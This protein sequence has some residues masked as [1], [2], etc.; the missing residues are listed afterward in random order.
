MRVL[1]GLSS[2][3]CFATSFTIDTRIF[4]E[5]ITRKSITIVNKCKPQVR[6][7]YLPVWYTDDSSSSR[8][9]TPEIADLAVCWNGFDEVKG[10]GGEFASYNY[11]C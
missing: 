6:S 5:N 2:A 9:S 1:E 10:G 4:K 7:K 8:C 3:L 11:I